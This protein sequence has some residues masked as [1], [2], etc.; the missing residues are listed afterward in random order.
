MTLYN[1][2]HN[3]IHLALISM[4]CSGGQNHGVNDISFAPFH[5]PQP[6][7]TPRQALGD[8]S[9]GVC[10]VWFRANCM[11]LLRGTSTG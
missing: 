1:G 9:W 4:W 5:D 10:G 6:Q 11:L 3:K 7:P 8:Q 2:C